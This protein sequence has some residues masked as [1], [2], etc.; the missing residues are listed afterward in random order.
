MTMK[1]AVQIQ[2][3]REVSGGTDERE[4]SAHSVVRRGALWKTPDAKPQAMFLEADPAAGRLKSFLAPGTQ[5]PRT[6]AGHGGR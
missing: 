6:S 3:Q 1:P 2:R 5:Y 4:E